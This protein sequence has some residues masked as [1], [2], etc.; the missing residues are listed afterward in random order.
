MY[1]PEIPFRANQKL[2]FCL[3]RTCVLTSNTAECCHTTDE[4]RALTG[5]WVIEEVWLTV[6][7]GYMILEVHEVYEYCSHKNQ[8]FVFSVIYSH[9][10]MLVSISLCFAMLRNACHL[11]LMFRNVAQHS[12]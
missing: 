7:K 12:Y 6:Q 10:L 2:M 4:E 9:T 5:T 1:H 11:F 8:I 3:C